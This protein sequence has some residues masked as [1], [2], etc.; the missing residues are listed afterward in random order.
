MSASLL[1][2]GEVDYNP[3]MTVF[4]W[5]L[6]RLPSIVVNKDTDPEHF[7]LPGHSPSLREVGAG[8]LC[9]AVVPMVHT[10]VF[11]MYPRTTC[12]GVALPAGQFDG[13]SSSVEALSSQMILALSS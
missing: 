9:T 2:A 4:S 5:R 11:L 1:C 3:D 13:S 7:T 12:P 8:K 10:A 6:P